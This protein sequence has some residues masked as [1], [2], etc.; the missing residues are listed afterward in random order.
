MS[1]KSDTTLRAEAM[2]QAI[3]NRA[4]AR[5]AKDAADRRAHRESE[6]QA[7]ADAAESAKL[8]RIYARA[9]KHADSIPD[10]QLKG[11]MF[12]IAQILGSKLLSADDRLYYA[13]VRDIMMVR[14]AHGA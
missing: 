11:F 1:K 14:T 3:T 6:R 12:S 10:D 8:D 9:K 5:K 13:N 7:N 4:A 2:A